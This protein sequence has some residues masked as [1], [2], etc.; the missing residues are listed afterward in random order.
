M[1]TLPGL[2]LSREYRAIA[3]RECAGGD[4]VAGGRAGP[5]GYLRVECRPERLAVDL[6]A[7]DDVTRA[8]SACRTLASFIV[9]DGRAGAERA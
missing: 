8:D 1:R 3:V 9:A 2:L 7:L 5:R 4:P 6:R